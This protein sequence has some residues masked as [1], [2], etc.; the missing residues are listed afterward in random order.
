SVLAVAFTIAGIILSEQMLRILG[1]PEEILP[2]ANSYLRIT[3]TGILFLFGYN[4]ISTVLRAIGD[5]KSPLRFVLIAV[6]LNV[7]LDPLFISGFN[8]GIEGAALAT[9]VSQGTAFLYGMYFVLRHKLIP[10]QLP[11]LPKFSEVT[12]I[13]KLGIP[14]GLQ[15]SVITAGSAAVMSVVTT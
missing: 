3:F 13:L 11:Y 8:L 6:V 2:L 14:A 10:F 1:T 12:L 7:I 15:M 5:S 9:I 4:F